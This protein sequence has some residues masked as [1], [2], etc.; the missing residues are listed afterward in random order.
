MPQKLLGA[1]IPIELGGDGASV[2]DLVEMSYALGGE[3][4][5]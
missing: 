4:S 3:L 1:Q 5:F 2:S